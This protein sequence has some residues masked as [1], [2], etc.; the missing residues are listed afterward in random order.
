METKLPEKVQKQLDEL[1]AIIS[2]CTDPDEGM[3]YADRLAN[4]TRKYKIKYGIGLPRG[5]MEQAQEIEPRFRVRPHLEYINDTLVKAVEDAEN[6]KERRICI[7]APP[8][9]GKT[10]LTSKFFI[11]WMLRKHPEWKIGI[12]SHDRVLAGQ[13]AGEIRTMIEEMPELGIR[14]APDGGGKTMWETR[15]GGGVYST[16]TRGALTG[17]GF[18]VL[19]VDDPVKGYVDANSAALRDTLWNWWLTD[20]R[21][22]MEPPS[23]VV[24]CATRF[25]YDDFIGRLLSDAYAGDPNEWTVINLPAL[26]R[27]GD[28]LGR[29]AGEPLISPLYEETKEQAKA[30]WEATLR[31]VGSKSFEA[32]YQ[33]RPLP[34]DGVV[35]QPDWIKFWTTIPEHVTAD[36]RTILLDPGMD[37]NTALWA[38]SWDL[39]FGE[40]GDFV[41]GQRW[42]ALGDERYLIDQQ[43]GRWAFVAQVQRMVGW[44]TR[45]PHNKYGD[46]VTRRLVEKKANGAAAL[47]VLKDKVR[48]LTPI[49]PNTSKELRAEVVAPQFEAGLVYFPDPLMPGY[50]WVL[51]TIEEIT[52]FPAAK[53]DDT[54]DAMSQFLT[55]AR[56]LRQKVSVAIPQ[57]Q[58]PSRATASGNNYAE[59]AKTIRSVSTRVTPTENHLP[60]GLGYSPQ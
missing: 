3:K 20:C 1:Q 33:G 24:V 39:T 25:H 29:E 37:L 22:R 6:G 59:M 12:I 58:L 54:V 28:A 17:R 47:D 52:Q 27:A 16:G 26:A 50:E 41:V 19:V 4:L 44:V 49:T 7:S 10:F 46:F 14:L 2:R 31:E 45:G 38:D 23:L 30:R 51:P 34:D 57:G 40:D 48:G 5:P 60:K 36:G 8:R 43:R 11:L 9:S 55:W 56:G 13:W 42:A 32:L 21:T 35:F 18:N 53:H 15:E